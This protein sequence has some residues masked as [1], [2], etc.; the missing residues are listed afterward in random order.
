MLYGQQSHM[1][2]EGREMWDQE[3]LFLFLFLMGVTTVHLCVIGWSYSKEQIIEDAGECDN[4]RTKSFTR[5][6]ECMASRTLEQQLPWDEREWS[7]MEIQR[8]A[9]NRFRYNSWS[10]EEP[11]VIFLLFPFSQWDERARS[12]TITIW[13]RL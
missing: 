10:G 11:E 4:C 2:V 13:T 5:W 9:E 3:F 8:K 7:P 6:K 1:A 12:S